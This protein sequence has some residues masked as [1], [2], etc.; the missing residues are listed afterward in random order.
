MT[1]AQLRDLYQRQSAAI[2]R[3]PHFALAVGHASVRFVAA[4]TCEVAHDQRALR[5]D[6]PP[7]EGGAGAEPYPG[8]LMRA[9][10]GAC[11]VMGYKLWG[12]RLGVPIEDATVDVTCEYDARGQLGLDAGVP[13]GWQRVCFE[14]TITSRAPEADVLRVVEHANRL[15]PMLANIAREVEKVHRVTVF[16][17]QG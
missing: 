17:S 7:E 15:S 8:E 11:L 12:A 10:L 4:M 9:S 14:V 5:V 13:I 6:L 2:A 16:R 1:P 3:R